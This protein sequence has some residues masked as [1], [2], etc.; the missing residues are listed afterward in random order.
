MPYKYSDPYRGKFKAKKY[1]VT[2]W[3]NYNQA[4]TKRGDITIWFK[5]DAIDTWYAEPAHK[6]GRQAVYSNAAIEIAGIISL[7]FRLPLRQ[8]TGFLSSIIKM[9]GLDLKIPDFSTLSRRFKKL[10][11]NLK[12]PDAGKGLHILVDAT[13]LSVYSADEFHQT[14]N[15]RTKFKGYRMLHIAI[16]ENREVLACEL[17]D[18]HANDKK[19]VPKLLK[20][21]HNTYDTFLADGNYD[22]R[23]VY[24]AIA[25]HK[26][27]KYI[28]VGEPRHCNVI[29]PPRINAWA[30]KTKGSLYPKQR[31][32][33]VR[34]R[35]EHGRINWQKATGYNERALV[36]VAFYRYKRIFGGM[37]HSHNFENQKAE[38][39]LACKALNVMT[40]LGM[41]KTVIV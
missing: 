8:T 1:K 28:K 38:A 27:S 29:I 12:I 21:I 34:Y 22:D 16:N 25:K 6:P 31:S 4:L 15:G 14:K 40:R 17:T 23:R 37:M 35:N 19:Q 32:D 24:E 5:E 30:R 41:P 33:H 11:R 20:N 13:G 9:M 7:V 18:K 36:E 39:Y 10:S 3:R 2:N 26:R